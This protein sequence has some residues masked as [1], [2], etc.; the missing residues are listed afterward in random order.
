M[1]ILICY[2][3]RPEY[4]KVKSL[5]DH[6]PNIETLCVYQHTDLLNHVENPTF[7]IKINEITNNRLNNIIISILSSVSFD[8]ISYVLVQGDTTTALALALSAFNNNVKVIH[9]E[10]GLRTY[11]KN[12]PYP[13]EINR[14]IISKIADVHCQVITLL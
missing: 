1:K 10:A 13:E 2:G 12:N 6:V 14:Q 4:I 8:N 7:A 11:D 5:I 9:L 3:T